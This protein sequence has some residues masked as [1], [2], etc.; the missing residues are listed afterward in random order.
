[1]SIS[2]SSINKLSLVRHLV[3][4]ESFITYSWQIL[5]ST[6][7]YQYIHNI[8][9]NYSILKYYPEDILDVPRSRSS[10][11]L[12]SIIPFS[13]SSTQFSCTV[14]KSVLLRPIDMA[15]CS[16]L[17]GCPSIKAG[18]ILSSGLENQFQQPSVSYVH[19]GH[20][21]NNP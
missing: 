10:Q 16:I 2:E 7:V 13:S 6:H 9:R 20:F 21:Q 12:C 11:F 4:P 14:R 19:N 17:W 5:C 15:Y 1:M 18:C 3:E 8:F